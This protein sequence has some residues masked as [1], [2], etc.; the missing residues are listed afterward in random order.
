MLRSFL[1]S[2]ERKER[3]WTIP[4]FVTKFLAK[5]FKILRIITK[6]KEIQSSFQSRRGK[7]YHKKFNQ[8]SKKWKDK[9]DKEIGGKE[10]RNKQTKKKKKKKKTGKKLILTKNKIKW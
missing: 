4:D 2:E 5:Y 8:F 1:W 6:R 3:Y 9:E 7:I 10:R